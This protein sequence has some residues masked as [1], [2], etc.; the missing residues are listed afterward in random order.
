MLRP[1][2]PHSKGR[3]VSGTLAHFVLPKDPDK[4]GKLEFALKTPPQ[5]GGWVEGSATMELVGQS[6]GKG[7]SLVD[8]IFGG[9]RLTAQP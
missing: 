1:A 7:Q 9:C 3:N 4:M 2:F 5:G 6:G 8:R